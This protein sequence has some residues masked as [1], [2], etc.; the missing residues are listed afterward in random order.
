MI[1]SKA[2]RFQPYFEACPERTLGFHPFK[3]P[4]NLQKI[5]KRID[6]GSA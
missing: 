5:F 2:K 1:S 3:I 4:E 6:S